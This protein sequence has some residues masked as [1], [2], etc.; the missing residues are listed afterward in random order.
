MAVQC[1]KRIPRAACALLLVATGHARIAGAQP[2]PASSEDTVRVS[3]MPYAW[4]NSVSPS[5][6]GLVLDGG[7]AFE[8]NAG[9]AEMLV[10]AVASPSAANGHPLTV[11]AAI[12]Y[13]I[14]D[15]TRV[16]WDLRFGVRVSRVDFVTSGPADAV[17]VVGSDTWTE[18]IGGARLG[19]RGKAW[20]TSFVA[21]I[22]GRPTDQFGSSLSLHGEAI[23]GYRV[24]K[25]LS[26]VGGYNLLRIWRDKGAL[27][28]D[29]S[30]HGLLM[31]IR[32]NARSGQ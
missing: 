22:G 13:R 16:D 7:F 23:L 11:D 20:S 8:L 25:R 28:L 24:T 1:L 14:L 17:P 12:G 27:N 2:A 31:G 6:A 4:A 32:V 15:G 5:S 19:I 9:R 10:E 3:L 18:N 26:V 29:R 21:D 30:Q